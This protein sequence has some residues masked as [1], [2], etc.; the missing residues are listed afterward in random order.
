MSY[1]SES[2]PGFDNTQ[3]NSLVGLIPE[4]Q[5]S[6][7]DSDVISPSI[8]SLSICSDCLSSS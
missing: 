6:G 2:G 4:K 3:F 7:I 5:G 1:C 8:S